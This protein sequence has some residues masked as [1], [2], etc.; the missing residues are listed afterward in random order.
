MAFAR[1]SGELQSLSSVDMKLIAL[2]HTLELRAHGHAN[3]RSRPPP[4][5][6]HAKGSAHARCC[7]PAH[8]CASLLHHETEVAMAM[9]CTIAPQEAAWLGGG[10]P[11]VGCAGPGQPGHG[12]SRQ[13]D[14][15]SCAGPQPGGEPAA[16]GWGV[17]GS[18]PAY[19]C[20]RSED[21]CVESAGC[22]LQARMQRR[23]AAQGLSRRRWAEAKRIQKMVVPG[24]WRH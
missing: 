9:C 1:D 4:P 12:C 18:P 21:L 20:L 10:G 2:A 16:R 19:V 5:R 22:A 23:P 11:R 13:Q 7:S 6:V 24:R 17:A 8:H 14:C 3:L 15:S